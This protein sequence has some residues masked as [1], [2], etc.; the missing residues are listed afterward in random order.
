M[1]SFDER[2]KGFEGKFQR[3]Q[4]LAFKVKARRNK[5]LG[6]WAAECLGL[7]GDAAEKYAR[8]VLASDLQQPGIDD[9]VAKVRD[10]FA[11]RGVAFDE[12]RIRVELERCQN[13]AK[14]QLGGG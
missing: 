4:E 13:E 6:L 5:L 3:D 9:I 11:K 7:K 12:T 10:D 2:E 14:K 1:S 8:E